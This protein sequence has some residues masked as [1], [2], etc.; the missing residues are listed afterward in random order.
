[1][2][3]QIIN[4]L[5]L[6]SYMINEAIK[7]PNLGGC[8]IIASIVAKHLEMIGISDV[9]ILVEKSVWSD[10]RT[11]ISL[12]KTSHDTTKLIKVTDWNELGVGFRHVVLKVNDGKKLKSS[13]RMDSNHLSQKIISLA[14]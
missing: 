5:N 12:I 10:H 9:E 1:M 7:K 14:H 6:V 2:N 3:K 13:T 8:A 4:V 11:D